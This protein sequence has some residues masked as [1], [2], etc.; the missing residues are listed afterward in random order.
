MNN[1]II[2]KSNNLFD[3]LKDSL[4]S[5]G[6][7]TSALLEA[8]LV[9]SIPVSFNPTCTNYPIN[10]NKLEI[11]IS[12]KYKYKIIDKLI[13]LANNPDLIEYYQKQIIKKKEGFFFLNRIIVFLNL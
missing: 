4:I 13:E 8:I 11:G 1:I 9:D 5:V 6:I 10:F 2:D 12:N 7:L 3:H